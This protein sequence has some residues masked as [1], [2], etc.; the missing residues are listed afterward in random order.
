[1][2]L[3]ELKYEELKDKARELGLKVAGNMKREELEV[4]IEEAM[5]EAEIA[6][7]EA[8][9]E[10]PTAESKAA[11]SDSKA[12]ADVRMG[13]L[14]L[15]KVIITPLDNRMKDIP[16]DMFSVGTKATGFIK[17]VVRFNRETIEPNIILKH[18]KEKQMLIQETSEVKGKL[19]TK[20]RS[21]PAYNIQE[22]EFT[23]EELEAIANK[24]KK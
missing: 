4:V 9:Y 2:N 6:A 21:V 14:Q 15:R 3:S 17:K 1:M 20:K 18:L 11:V 7:K 16:S 24:G 10:K 23:K 22:L 19:I 8:T 12:K 13:A 5:A